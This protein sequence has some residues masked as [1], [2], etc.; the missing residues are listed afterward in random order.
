MFWALEPDYKPQFNQSLPR[1]TL[2]PNPHSVPSV[3]NEDELILKDT[4]LHHLEVIN[5]NESNILLH[6]STKDLHH[7][8]KW[9]YGIYK[10]I[11]Y[12]GENEGKIYKKDEYFYIGTHM[13]FIFQKI[14]VKEI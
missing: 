8:N 5:L 14:G 13:S 1:A 11:V 10:P 6:S 7:K 3:P 9:K 4:P 12:E 2:P